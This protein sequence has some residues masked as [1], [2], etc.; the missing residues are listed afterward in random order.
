M[1]TDHLE[2]PEMLIDFDPFLFLNEVEGGI[3]RLSESSL[4]NVSSGGGVT[5][6]VVLEDD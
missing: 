3:V 5:S 6:L 2:W 1:F 4:C